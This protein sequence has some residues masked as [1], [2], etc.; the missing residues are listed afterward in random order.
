[1]DVKTPWLQEQQAGSPATTTAIDQQP[2]WTKIV[3]SHMAKKIDTQVQPWTTPTW[4]NEVKLL[5]KKMERSNRNG[6]RN[7]RR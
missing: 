3:Q 4:N 2:K 5:S 7:G 6:R 1:V